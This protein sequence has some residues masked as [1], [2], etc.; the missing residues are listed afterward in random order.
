MYRTEGIRDTLQE[1]Q[2]DAAVYPKSWSILHAFET[3]LTTFS[4]VVLMFLQ[5]R[6][7]C[8]NCFLCSIPLT[9]P[10]KLAYGVILYLNLRQ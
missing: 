6:S 2:D 10:T 3:E 8:M 7:P 5:C 4:H 9:P 1:F